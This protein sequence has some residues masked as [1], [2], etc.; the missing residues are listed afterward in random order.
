LSSCLEEIL[1][2]TNERPAT[3]WRA[4]TALE[5][6]STSRNSRRNTDRLRLPRELPLQES[7]WRRR[8][9]ARR[10]RARGQ[11]NPHE[12]GDGAFA[13]GVVRCSSR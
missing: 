9:S 6:S 1:L 10:M 3:A 7:N 5:R 2:H 8:S 12:V 11:C 13:L 4:R